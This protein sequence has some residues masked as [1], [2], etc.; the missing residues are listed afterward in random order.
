ML[1]YKK[2][3][4]ENERL[5]AENEALRKFAERTDRRM[6]KQWENFFSYDGT[7]RPEVSNED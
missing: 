2:L 1:R 3:K 4:E 7:A 6:A 5:R